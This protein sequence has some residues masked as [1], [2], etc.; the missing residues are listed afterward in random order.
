MS[1]WRPHDDRCSHPLPRRTPKTLRIFLTISLSACIYWFLSIKTVTY[2]P[3]RAAL[4]VTN[5]ELGTLLGIT[6]FVQVFGYITLGWLQ[7]M[8][9]IRGI[10]MIDL[11]VYA[12]LALSL[13]L[14]PTPPFWWLCVVFAGFGLFGEALYWPTVQKA[15]RGMS[16]PTHQAALFS[17]QEALRGAMGFI[18]NLVTLLLF[19]TFGSQVIGVRMAMIC[20]PL[21]MVALAYVVFHNVPADFLQKTP[22]MH[23]VATKRPRTSPGIVLTTLRSPIVWTTGLAAFAGYTAYIAVTT[24]ALVLFQSTFSINDT[25][26]AALGMINTGILPVVAALLSGWIARRFR[27]SS[28]WMT[29]LFVAAATLSFAVI[30]LSGSDTPYAGLIATGFLALCCY[31]IRAVYFVPIGEYDIDDAHAAT[32]MS[33]A[34]FLGYLP[35]F[36]AYPIFGTI[37]DAASNGHSAQRTIFL[38]LG[39]VCIIGMLISVAG[40][41]LIEQRRRQRPW[42]TLIPITMV[43]EEHS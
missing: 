27:S 8:L 12:L 32:V 19:V 14:L 41:L 7:D 36:L 4:G 40:H 6:G 42:P 34:S 23:E 3:F 13:A 11:I 31:A 18:A 25:Y 33:V 21:V 15:T 24:Y 22:E 38:V 9:Q 29:V 26:I 17:T 10:I 35:S 5:A 2:E 28:Q 43:K 37:I 39:I 16:G 30:P 1:Q 20:Y